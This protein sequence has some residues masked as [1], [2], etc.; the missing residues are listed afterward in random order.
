MESEERPLLVHKDQFEWLDTKWALTSLPLV[1]S[2]FPVSLVALPW[3]WEVIGFVAALPTWFGILTVLRGRLKS[4][5]IE[6]VLDNNEG[7]FFDMAMALGE[8]R[9]R[10]LWDDSGH[11]Q[12]MAWTGAHYESLRRQMAEQLDVIL[13]ACSSVSQVNEVIEGIGAKSQSYA[14]LRQMRSGRFA[15]DFREKGFGIDV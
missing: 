3:Y 7:V 1:L 15:Q 10:G 13:P 6:E 2:G 11:D 8:G 4:K 5:W 14:G 9:A 12:S